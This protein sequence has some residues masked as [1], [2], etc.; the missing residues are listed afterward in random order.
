MVDNQKRKERILIVGGGKGG[1]A[2]LETFKDDPLLEIVGIIDINNQAPGIKLAQAINIET[3]THYDDFLDQDLD[4]VINVTG[5]KE[6]ME[7]LKCKLQGRETVLI[8]GA[9]AKFLWS[10]LEEREAQGAVLRN[11]FHRL[12]FHIEHTPMGAIEWDREFRITAWNPSAEKIFGFKREEVI[13]R[14]GYNSIIPQDVKPKMDI[15]IN[16]LKEG[17]HRHSIN[18]NLTKDGRRIICEWFHTPLFDSQ[19]NIIG[20]A[21]LV[22]DVTER[23]RLQ[24]RVIRESTINSALADVSEAVISSFSIEEVANLIL[25][26]ALEF[27]K[28][29]SGYVGAIN[30]EDD[31]LM[32]PASTDDRWRGLLQEVNLNKSYPLIKWIID[33]KE[34]LIINK[35]PQESPIKNMDNKGFPISRLLFVPARVGS[36]V[37]GLIGVA[38]APSDYSEEELTILKR[39]G[40]FLGLFLQRRYMEEEVR[41]FNE[42]LEEAVTKRT[43]ELESLYE[44][45][46]KI[47]HVFDLKQFFNLVFLCLGKIIKCDLIGSLFITEEKPRVFVSTSPNTSPNVV[48]DFLSRLQSIKDKCNLGLPFPLQKIDVE[49]LG[50]SQEGTSGKF[51]QIKTI[52]Q[53]PITIEANTRGCLCLCFKDDKALS[54]DELRFFNTL[55]CQVSLSLERIEVLLKAQERE[56][57]S[58]IHSLPEGVVLLNKEG[59]ILLSNPA[60]RDLVSSFMKL[61]KGDKLNTIG[62]VDLKEIMNKVNQMCEIKID[63]PRKIILEATFTPVAKGI[64]GREAGILLMRDVTQIREREKYTRQQERLATVGQLAGGIAHEFN[65]ILNIIMVTTDLVSSIESNLNPETKE[66]L[67]NI[68]FQGRRAAALVRQVLDFSRTSITQKKPLDLAY[69]LK[70]IEN[71]V[72]QT[73]PE[74]IEIK[75]EIEERDKTHIVIADVFQMEQVLMNLITNARDAMPEGGS[76]SIRIKKLTVEKAESAPLS[77]MGPGSYVVLEVE[78]TGCGMSE[79]ILKRAFEP[80]FTTKQVGKGA[81]L[82]LS[83]VYGIV[84]QH[85]GFITIKS[86]PEKGTKVIVYFPEYKGEK[87]VFDDLIVSKELSQE[88]IYKGNGEQILLVEDNTFVCEVIKNGLERLNY[89]IT[90]A[91]DAQEGLKIYKENKDS[92]AL[93]ISDVVMPHMDGVKFYHEIKKIK[94]GA[95]VI[96]ISGYGPFEE[97]ETLIQEGVSFLPKPVDIRK[98]SFQIKEILKRQ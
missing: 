24:E 83:Q 90:V 69:F 62:N 49:F 74:N 48:S 10:L 30:F 13:G 87:E 4:V 32:Y 1:C 2:L 85:N 36:V 42:R 19:G 43:S 20:A 86:H 71:L 23:K 58:I 67:K 25:E 82:G 44:F 15:I 61:R 37:F 96:L 59:V 81:G 54:E 5:Q 93:I 98:L 46:Q 16:E 33:K 68:K 40:E 78:D 29:K 11:A 97:L 8:D 60:A 45:S 35:F 6:V 77:V 39:L 12:S 38:N 55:V 21:S 73:I 53:L 89:K 92:V 70:G 47:L 63:H 28:S 75:I 95:K 26:K 22:W 34:H 9:S 91:H 18:D 27:T 41:K 7:D 31:V 72:R 94:P 17:K 79:D 64:L 3:S 56:L 14:S 51:D 76:L 50:L 66:W 88:D 65:N 57:E 80:F 52:Y 84:E